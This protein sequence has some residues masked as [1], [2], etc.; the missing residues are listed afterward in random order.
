MITVVAML[1]DGYE[2]TMEHLCWRQI[3]AAFKVNRLICIGHDCQTMT[4]ALCRVSPEDRRVFVVPPGR[5]PKSVEFDDYS[6][7]ESVVFIFGKPGN[8]LV[9]YIAER[10]DAVHI[11]TPGPAD[12]MAITVAG[13]ILK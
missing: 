5:T 6:V 13:M 10:D 4:Q 8:N 12:L 2:S 1:E 11:T 3:R 9:K 7:P